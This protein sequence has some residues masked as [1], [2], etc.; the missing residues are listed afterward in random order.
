MGKSKTSTRPQDA[1]LFASGDWVR[2]MVRGSPDSLAETAVAVGVG[3]GNGVCV[4][5]G[6]S[7]TVGDGVMVAVG[8]G[9]DNAWGEAEIWVTICGCSEF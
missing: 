1:P 5:D 6:V 2:L 9:V 8:C 7:V 4:G 3:V